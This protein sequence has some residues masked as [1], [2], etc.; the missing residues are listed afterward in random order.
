M[1]PRSLGTIVFGVLAAMA[2]P[3]PAHVPYAHPRS[4]FESRADLAEPELIRIRKHLAQ[5]E[6]DLRAHPP[7]GLSRNNPGAGR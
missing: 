5:V 2:A 1:L 3:V 4:Y 6:S 7:K